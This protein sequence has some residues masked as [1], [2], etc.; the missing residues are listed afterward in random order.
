L[1]VYGVP[2][3][4]VP[5]SRVALGCELLGG[6]DWGVV[7]LEEVV[8]T[9]RRAYDSGVTVF[10]TADVYGLG[11]SETVLSRALGKRIS[12]VIVI[13]KGGI[14]WDAIGDGRAETRRDLSPEYLRRAVEASLR[15]LG[16][17]QIP[18]Y[19][20]HWPDGVHPVEQVVANL[21]ELREMGLIAAFGLSNFSVA[22]LS[23]RDVIDAIDAIELE[24]N[25]LRQ[26]S[27]AI[28]LAD[29]ADKPSFLYGAL[30]QGMLTGKYRPGTQFPTSDR[31]HRLSQFTRPGDRD[32][33][34]I[35]SV[36]EA[37]VE[38]E[39]TPSQIAIRWVLQSSARACAV[40]GAR[41]RSQLDDNVRAVELLPGEV[42]ARLS[43]VAAGQSA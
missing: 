41:T 29:R 3:S 36:I 42:F 31:R 16:I 1:N 39:T 10:D 11:R 28:S 34:V 37:A 38:L 25:L 23:Q 4:A 8:A 13:T 35:D 15:R 27:S 19:L 21:I 20:A 18:L 43:A 2:W 40:V 17:D 6:T 14:A 32:R 33:Q 24:H 12:D 9:V 7:D 5:V 26:S 30:A 22:D